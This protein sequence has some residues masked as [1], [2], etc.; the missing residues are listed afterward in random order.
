MLTLLVH[1]VGMGAGQAAVLVEVPDVVGET[2]AAGTT[3]LETALFV[4]SVTTDYSSSVAAGLIISQ[5][6]VGG[7]FAAQGSTVGI[8]VSLGPEPSDEQPSGGWAFYNDYE[9]ELRR[10]RKR[11]KERDELE[12]ETERIQN[13]LDRSIAQLLREQEAKDEK[14]AD[15][16]RLK[17]LAKK[18]ADLE[19]AR[20]Y[21]ER[22]ATAYARAI[23][24]G[25]FSALEALDREL[26]RAREEDEFMAAALIH[27]LH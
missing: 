12:A 15:L 24:Q 16:N 27:F 17:E 1:G 2:Q 9:I 22:V 13:E 3:T 4:V 19:A 18:H 8:V 23:T 7:S 20:Q 25:N 14:R 10:R 6:P 11:K 26:Q 21:S 5:S